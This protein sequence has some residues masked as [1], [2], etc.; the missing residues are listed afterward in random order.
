[1]KGI[2][3]SI[4][5]AIFSRRNSFLGRNGLGLCRLGSP[6]PDSIYRTQ[7]SGASL[8][9]RLR[10]TADFRAIALLMLAMLSLALLGSATGCAAKIN[11]RESLAA[12]GRAPEGSPRLLAIY[13]PWFGQKEHI[14]VGYS[15]H[16]PNVLRQQ[17]VKAKELNISGFVVNWYGPRKE[18]EDQAYG[19]MQQA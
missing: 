14:N 17:I 1:M 15:C 19:L 18:F 8:V 9:P 3:I 7:G 16:D 12:Q 4:S 6:A 10:R 13:Q 11:P 2:L 5:K